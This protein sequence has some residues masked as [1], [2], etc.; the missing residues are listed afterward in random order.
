MGHWRFQTPTIVL[1]L[2]MIEMSVRRIIQISRS[3][4]VQAS[5]ACLALLYCGFLSYRAVSDYRAA[6]GFSATGSYAHNQMAAWLQQHA[7]PRDQLGMFDAGFVPYRCN[8]QVIDLG[9]LNNRGLSRIPG[10]RHG[11][12]AA[13][14]YVMSLQPRYVV[15][16]TKKPWPQYH[17]DAAYEP[18]TERLQQHPDFRQNYKFA[19][20]WQ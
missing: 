8:L 6:R 1:A 20:Q 16:W 11:S 13:A 15:M 2:P 7:N 5:F 18:V 14:D 10:Y 9:G 19:L 3:Q 12:P 17:F 4:A